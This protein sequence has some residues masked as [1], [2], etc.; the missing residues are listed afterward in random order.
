[1]V[2]GGLFVQE[3]ETPRKFKAEKVDFCWVDLQQE[4]KESNHIFLTT[5]MSFQGDET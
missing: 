3:L 2:V 1:M 5:L 4:G